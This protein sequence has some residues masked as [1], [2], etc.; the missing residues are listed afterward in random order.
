[1]AV[2]VTVILS[3]EDY[4]RVRSMAGPV[5]LTR[6]FRGLAFPGESGGESSHPRAA[7]VRKDGEV[8]VSRGWEPAADRDGLGITELDATAPTATSVT[9]K[10][11]LPIPKSTKKGKPDAITPCRHGLLYCQRCVDMGG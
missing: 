8:R 2:R 7:T 10:V 11:S 5:P 3:D 6:W 4:A 1:M 9:G